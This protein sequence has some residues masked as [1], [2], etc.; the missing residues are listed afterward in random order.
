MA[1]GSIILSLFIFDNPRL[2]TASLYH[3]GMDV[4]GAFVCAVLFYGSMWQLEHSTRSFSLLVVLVSASFALNELMWFT[5]GTPEFCTLY[6][7]CC[8]LSKW[9]NLA[10]IYCFYLYVSGTLYFTGKLAKWANRAFP[11]LL[12]VSMLIVLSNAVYPVSFFVDGNGAYGKGSLPWLEDLF[13]IIASDA[14]AP[15]DKNGRQCPLS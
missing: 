3:A 8:V 15:A 13:L 11:V 1:L 4:L 2:E 9:I 5:A 14:Q 7:W 6:F 12:V 10:M